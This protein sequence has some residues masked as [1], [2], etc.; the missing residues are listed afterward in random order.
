[1]SDNKFEM[2]FKTTTDKNKTIIIEVSRDDTVKKIKQLIAVKENKCVDQIKIMYK[3][4]QMEDG[5]T[6]SDYKVI[7]WPIYI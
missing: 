1:M 5:R 4:E 3:G 6:L 7:R 2:W